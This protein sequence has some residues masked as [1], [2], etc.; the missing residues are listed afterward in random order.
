MD[1]CE[2]F[3]CVDVLDLNGCM[4]DDFVVDDWW[5]QWVQVL[6]DLDDV[7]V[8]F[9]NGYWGVMVWL[10]L[11]VCQDW[12]VW[13]NVGNVWFGWW[14]FL[15]LLEQVCVQVVGMFGVDFD[16]I[17]IMCGVIEVMQ[18]LIVGYCWFLL[19]DMVMYVDID[20]DSMIIVMQWLGE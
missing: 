3:D 2:W 20:Y 12:M 6:Y 8:M 18:V 11:Q 15:L 4:F 16:E 5:W 1:V 14:V 9:D 10:V 13:V 19:G 7:V 17:V